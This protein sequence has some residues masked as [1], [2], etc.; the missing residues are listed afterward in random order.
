MAKHAWIKSIFGGASFHLRNFVQ[1]TG[2]SAAVE[3]AVVAPVIMLMT[4]TASDLG[5]AIS[6]RMAMDGLLR[7][8]MHAVNEGRSIDEIAQMMTE[9]SASRFSS[10][11]NFEVDEYCTCGS[12]TGAVVS[13]SAICTDGAPRVFLQLSAHTTP[14]SFLLSGAEMVPSIYLQVR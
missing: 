4:L 14:S 3:F 10:L 11:P 1:Q 2:A 13:C 8:G 12:A 6:N 5:G 9:A 7:S